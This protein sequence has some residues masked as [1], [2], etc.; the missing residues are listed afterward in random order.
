MSLRAPGDETANNQVSMVVM[1]LAT[2][3]ADPLVRLQRIAAASANTKGLVGRVKAAIATDSRMLAAPWLMSGLA[4]LSTRSRSR[5]T[6]W[7]ST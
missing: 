2:D 6:A 3:V 4:S 5:R 1:T 7:R